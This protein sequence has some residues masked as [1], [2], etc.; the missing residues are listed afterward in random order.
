[1][2]IMLLGGGVGDMTKTSPRQLFDQLDDTEFSF[3]VTDGGT[4]VPLRGLGITLTGFS[5]DVAWSTETVTFL[6]YSRAS[7]SGG[8]ELLAVGGASASS[9]AESLLLITLENALVGRISAKYAWQVDPQYDVPPPGVV[10]DV[11]VVSNG[12]TTTFSASKV[13]A[14][15]GGALKKISLSANAMAEHQAVFSREFENAILGR[16]QSELPERIIRRG[17]PV[18]IDFADGASHVFRP[19][20]GAPAQLVLTQVDAR[21]RVVDLEF[22]GT[23][24]EAVPVGSF[25]HLNKWMA[26]QLVGILPP[27]APGNASQ[28]EV[29]LHSIDRKLAPTLGV[30]VGF[31]TYARQE[32]SR[33]L[34]DEARLISGGDDPAYEFE[35][36]LRNES[37]SAASI[38]E[39][40]ATFDPDS[41]GRLSTVRR[42]EGTYVTLVAK[43]LD[44]STTGPDRKRQASAW[45]PNP[46]GQR[47]IVVS[48]TVEFVAAKSGRTIVLRIEFAPGAIEWPPSSVD[49]ELTC[50]G[51]QTVQAGRVSL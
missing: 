16:W 22:G 25:T 40:R 31:S 21:N 3:Y 30:D 46:D 12:A 41:R 14:S 49:L 7:A 44:A 39:I 9:E 13:E 48:P 5:G 18:I 2:D 11:Y 28:L 10:Q 27:S 33:I 29:M 35:F 42:L 34:L 38:T 51:M 32:D 19:D 1:M 15:A 50:N 43:D 20:G 17:E 8:I 36:V 37:D 23:K 45:Y 47:L 26:I 6:A 4:R 24:A